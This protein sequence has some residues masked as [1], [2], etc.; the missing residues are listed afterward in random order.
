[1]DN[2]LAFAT[3]D[4][5]APRI[6]SGELSP[7][8]LV[9]NCL[10]RIA[11]HGKTLN[12]FLAVFE[13]QAREDAKT[14]EAE[15]GAGKW[16]GPLHGIPIGL[17]DLV[18]VAGTVTTGGSTILKE[19]VASADATITRKLKD[20]GAIIIGKTHMVEFA[21]GAS[22]INPHY[23][24]GRNPW[25]L[26]R[27]T[28]G[29][30]IGSGNA[31]GGG[32][33]Y[34]AIGS[35]TGGSIR[36]PAAVCGIAGLKPT[37]GV[38]SRAG[39]LDLSWSC[40]HV[41][42]MTRSVADAAHMMNALA[43]YDAADPASSSEVPS[44]YGA[45][46]SGSLDGVRVGVPEHYFF[47]SIDAEI[48]AAV[49][50]AIE[51]MASHGAVVSTISMEWVR[52]G[53]PI[54]LGVMMPEA[55]SVHEKWLNA[56]RDQYSLEVLSRLSAGVG[57][58]AQDYIKAQRSRAWFIEK[59]RVAMADVD[60]LVTPTIPIQTPTIEGCTPA[61]GE[62]VARDGGELGNFTGVFNTSGSPSLSVTC[63]FTDDGMPIGMM[64]TGKAYRDDVV[65]S[66]GDA[67]ERVATWQERRPEGFA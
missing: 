66:V 20:A 4:E 3:I 17:K 40:D 19:N 42:P 16:R 2:D 59:L 67:Y 8:T 44:D 54:N 48:E 36:M 31:V 41:G 45:A 29:S 60:V 64:I 46:L 14:L 9:E 47:E 58:S 32:L 7:V 62:N 34:G 28:C 35:D 23:G 10:E 65:L 53:R 52:L 33:I 12:S 21:M 5:L 26:D 38:V 6:K 13:Q 43:G 15:I 1:M 57:I 11:A 63:G 25:N 27:I 30:S 22:G 39:V 55:V 56:H 37:Y 24:P 18:D 50:S 61:P 49:R 51:L